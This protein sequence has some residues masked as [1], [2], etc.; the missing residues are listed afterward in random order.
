MQTTSRWYIANGP[1]H[2]FP[3][4]TTQIPAGTHIVENLL[5]GRCIIIRKPGYKVL[6]GYPHDFQVVIAGNDQPDDSVSHG[7]ILTEFV[8]ALQFD[9][10]L[11]EVFI[12]QAFSIFA[13]AEIP[14]SHP[15]LG[16][17]RAPEAIL[18]ALKWI[19]AE[20]DVNYPISRGKQ[21]RRMAADRLAEVLH[22]VELDTVLIRANV[23]YGR[24]PARLAGV[25][26]SMVDRLIPR[27]G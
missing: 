10:A 21:G 22:G 5:D 12:A 11:G 7:D 26:Y 27:P 4:K 16:T 23:K 13:G 19:L 8:S 17:Q 3:P 1:Y 9:R 2:E 6:Q 20:E 15:D 18:K 25:D 14:N 24:P